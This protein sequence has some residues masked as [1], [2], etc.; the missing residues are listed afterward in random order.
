[1]QKDLKHYRQSYEKSELA[2]DNLPS[3]PLALFSA[4]FKDAEDHPEIAEPNAMSLATVGEDMTPTSRVVLLKSFSSDGFTFYTNYNSEKGKDLAEN[5][6]LCISFFWPALERQVIIQG[7]AVK[8]S[9]KDSDEYFRVRPRGSQ[10]GAWASQQSQE[11]PSHQYLIDE[12]KKLEEKFK[13]GE[14]PRPGHWGGYLIEPFHFEFWQGRRNRLHDRVQYEKNT[15]G[16]W[17]IKRVA[18]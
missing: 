1:M 7:I 18:P 14:I 6:K 15:N 11:I 4:W 3:Q 12:M 13:A 5:P 10:L 16:D 8:T 17:K 2:H 9:A